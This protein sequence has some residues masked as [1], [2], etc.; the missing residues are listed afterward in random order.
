MEWEIENEIGEEQSGFT[1]GKSCINNMYK[2]QQFLEEKMTKN[3]HV[4][5]ALT[6]LK[7]ADDNLKPRTKIWEEM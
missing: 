3:R 1:A 4:H 2:V 5:T 6:E 7:K